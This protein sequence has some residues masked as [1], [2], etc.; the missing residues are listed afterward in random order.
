MGK[1]ETTCGPVVLSQAYPL[2]K[3]REFPSEGNQCLL[4]HQPSHSCTQWRQRTPSSEGELRKQ[5]TVQ[6]INL[7]EQISEVGK[8]YDVFEGLFSIHICTR[9]AS[10]TYMYT[11]VYNTC[12]TSPG[13]VLCCQICSHYMYI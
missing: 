6:F 5:S 10:H 12:T 11:A 8:C 7:R 2:L 13:N 4:G 9:I 1:M 3:R